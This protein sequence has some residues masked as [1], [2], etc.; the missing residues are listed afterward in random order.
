MKKRLFGLILALAMVIAIAPMALAT[1]STECPDGDSC[2]HV[3]AIG[4]THYGTLKDAIDKVQSG[5]TIVMIDDVPNAKGITVES[6]KNFTIDFADHTYTLSGPGA[7]SSGTE[8]NGFQLLKDSTITFKNGTICIAEG[9]NNIKRIIQ[10]YANLTLENMQIY[11]KNQQDGEDYALSFNNGD[12]VFKGNTSVYTT[13]DDTIAFDVCKY[14]SYPSTIVTFDKSYTGTINGVII[15]DS[16]DASTHKL[17]IDGNGSFGKIEVSQGSAASPSI[18]ITG[19][20]FSDDV[21]AYVPEGNVQNSDGTIGVA[22]SAVAK[23]GN[24][25]YLSFKAAFSSVKEGETITLLADMTNDNYGTPVTVQGENTM[26]HIDKNITILGNGHSITLTIPETF[27]DSEQ[28]IGVDSGKTLTLDG[29]ALTINGKQNN[30]GDAFDLYGSLTIQGGSNITVNGGRSAFTMQGGAN[31]NVKISENSAVSA[32]GINGNFSNGGTWEIKDSTVSI[33]SC[34][35]HGLSVQTLTADN[36]TINVSKTGQVGVLGKEVMLKNG[37]EIYVTGSGSKLPGDKA[38][39]APDGES[40]KNVM[41]LKQGGT[42]SVDASS[43]LILSN[44][45]GNNGQSVSYIWAGKSNI[46]IQGTLVADGI[47]GEAPD[48]SFTVTVMSDNQIVAIGTVEAQY[49]LPAAPV[50]TSYAFQGWSDGSRTYQPGETA[51]ISGN[52]TFTALWQ[53]IPPADPSYQIT[54]PATAN[55]TVT[56]S[57][58]S[59]KEDQVVTITVTPD[60]G[61]ELTALTVTDFFGNQ[62]DISRNSDGTYSFVMPAS[63]VTVSAVFAPAQLPFT[64][65]TEANWYYD[66]VYYVWAN[67]LMQGTSATTFGPGVDT[68]RAMVV[69]ILWRLEGEPAS[70]YDMDYS[71]VAGG[72]WYAGAVRWATEHGIVNGSEGQFYP[73]GTVTREQLAAMLYRYAQYKGYDLTAGGDLSGFADAGAVSGW[74]ETSLAWA[75]GQRLIQG[76][77]NQIDPTGSAIRAQLAAI[78]MRFMENVAN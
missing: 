42:L 54:I 38:T 58:T 46:N 52:T 8:T 74:A 4:G 5:G 23:I 36:S 1:S 78:L 48:G 77:A 30:K 19:G 50:K 56:V 57:P 62:V 13:S 21:S 14:A 6:N 75:V 32:T 70:G 9:A 40:Y 76:S 68:T 12:I 65:V 39:W 18:S 33:N 37:A 60:S 47:K 59:A 73:G 7:G 24:K 2:T 27:G 34:G 55:G 63:Q 17:F 53:Y 20:T 69:T 67:G 28:A 61:S 72:A 43:S 71:D 26:L 64:D 29:V 51:T 16:S 22:D 3:A 49:T 66:E 41:E 35:D 10:N 15:Y 11:A 31:S 45:I 25:G 44:N